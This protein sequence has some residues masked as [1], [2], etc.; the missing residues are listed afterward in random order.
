MKWYCWFLIG[1]H[2]LN[3]S[4]AVAEENQEKISMVL[5]RVLLMTPFYYY[6]IWEIK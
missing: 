3:F 6:F 5:F 2:F 1:L 4:A